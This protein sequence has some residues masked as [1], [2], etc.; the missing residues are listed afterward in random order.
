M[1]PVAVEGAGASRHRPHSAHPPIGKVRR[2]VREIGLAMVTAGVV[3]LAFVTYQLWGTSFHEQHAQANLKR[4][5]NSA[6][7]ANHGSAPSPGSTTAKSGGTTSG[8]SDNPTIGSGR[9]ASLSP[10]TPPGTAVDHLVIPKIGVNKYVVQGTADAN[11]SQGPGHYVNTPFPGQRG[12]AAIAGHRTTYG[13]PFFRLNDLKAGDRIYLTDTSGRIFVYRVVK[14]KVVSP[15]DVSVLDDTPNAELTLTTCNP[16]FSATSRLVAVSDLIGRPEAASSTTAKT[17]T[18]AKTQAPSS[19]TVPSTPTSTTSAAAT[20]NLG[21]GNSNGW[22]PAIAYGAAF[23]VLW[24][25]ARLAINRT[26]R[27]SRVAAFVVGIGICAIPLWFC[28]ENV[29]RLLPAAI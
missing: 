1:Q 17:R 21:S 27:W 26:R 11:L 12:N 29:V 25:G 13:A 18:K 15:S 20:S 5:F 16:A 3:V 24:I 19:T 14:L 28:F 22:P 9:T 8:G 23:V 4:S 7:A 10:S 6:V 2:T